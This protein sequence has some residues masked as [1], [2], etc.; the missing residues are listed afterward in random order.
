MAAESD[1]QLQLDVLLDRWD[2]LVER[3]IEPNAEE[4]CGECPELLPGFRRCLQELQ[5][6]DSVLSASRE[7][8]DE[9]TRPDHAAINRGRFRLVNLDRPLGEGGLGRVFEAADDE[10]G[11]SVAVKC[12]KAWS[13]D[14]AGQRRFLLEAR[15][16]AQLEHPGVVPVYG[17]GEGKPESSPYYAMRKIRG[18]TL[19][20]AADE[21]FSRPA[22]QIWNSAEWMV[23][24]R[25]LLQRFISICQTVAYAHD[26]GVIHRDIK[27]ANIMFGPYGESLLMDWGLAKWT[28]LE[29]SAEDEASQRLTAEYSDPATMTV[30]GIV[31]GSPYFMSPEQARS[32]WAHVGKASDIYSLGATLFVLITGQA[33]F[34]SGNKGILEVLQQVQDGTFPAPRAVRSKVPAPLDAVC[35][36][37]MAREPRDRY[38]TVKELAADLE[39]WLA[40]EPVSCCQDPWSV[41]AAR[42]VRKHQGMAVGGAVFLCISVCAAGLIAFQST[43]HA[44][45]LKR[46]LERTQRYAKMSRETSRE[47]A[48]FA[49]GD[50]AAKNAT[51]IFFPPNVDPSVISGLEL[52]AS[53]YE[54]MLSE[55]PD[56]IE[57]H[58]DL[59]RTRS[60]LAAA[61][62]EM[63]RISDAEQILKAQFDVLAGLK[64]QVETDLEL[65]FIDA[66]AWTQ[67][68]RLSFRQVFPA[69]EK[70]QDK[71]L[72]EAAQAHLRTAID[73]LE[74]AEKS[75][76]R[77]LSPT[78]SDDRAQL[79]LANIRGLNGFIKVSL[80]EDGIDAAQESFDLM[81]SLCERMPDVLYIQE[82]RNDAQMILG[83]ALLSETQKHASEV[84]PHSN[85]LGGSIDD[86]F[87]HPLDNAI[88]ESNRVQDLL[89]PIARTR[90]SMQDE[91][92]VEF[93]RLYSSHLELRGRLL[94]ERLKRLYATRTIVNEQ[95]VDATVH[96]IF[97][98][99][100]PVWEET[101]AQYSENRVIV[102]RLPW[103]RMG[104]AESC[105]DSLARFDL[106]TEQ[107]RTDATASLKSALSALDQLPDTLKT[108]AGIDG[109][110]QDIAHRIQILTNPVLQ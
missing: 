59:I 110:R 76:R 55:D 94:E 109:L 73:R 56:D 62:G 80:D 83:M 44:A 75:V 1:E 93:D 77:L 48:S 9:F 74:V 91:K 22:E 46:N 39:R 36:K 108:D 72:D 30:D 68:A 8:T 37:A 24:V 99:A 107:G 64:Q 7:N 32:D 87:G 66:L 63:G 45:E 33:P 31:K 3:G 54:K 12:M 49:I 85:L 41:R 78:S 57:S 84:I 2:E 104:F 4:I 40:G 61:Y 20:A 16:A 38:G 101:V 96:S 13:A 79:L 67:Y 102:Q 5:F 70:I 47:L 42:W 95:M 69:N 11:R 15:L 26:R 92:R 86:L 52:A 81:K 106:T 25:R 50:P 98:E 58:R 23:D 89:R 10:L 71:E 35:R 53:A 105:R 14:E 88:N 29:H 19:A 51:L 34:E 97:A 82:A 6:V 100:L 65:A 27:P 103:L 90:G 28:S 21:L 43:R 17:M 18:M 60:L